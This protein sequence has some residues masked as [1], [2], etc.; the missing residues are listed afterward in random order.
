[1]LFIT[2]WKSAK[3]ETRFEACRLSTTYFDRL[4]TGQ[5]H[6]TEESENDDGDDGDDARGVPTSLS[7]LWTPP[8]FA[9][10]HQFQG[11]RIV[12]WERIRAL[13]QFTYIFFIVS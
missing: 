3:I 9:F 1:M 5:M 4:E 2:Y 6:H 11:R 12:S 8:Y 13:L 7:E 10:S